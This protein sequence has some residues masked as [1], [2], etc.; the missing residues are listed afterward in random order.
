MRDFWEGEHERRRR[1]PWV[2]SWRWR[3]EEMSLGSDRPEER[4]TNPPLES[5][6][7]SV[8]MCSWNCTIS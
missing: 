3:R 2:G 7:R 8:M 5:S 6:S 1:V 4:I